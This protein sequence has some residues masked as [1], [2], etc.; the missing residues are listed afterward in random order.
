MCSRD[1]QFWIPT[2]ERNVLSLRKLLEAAIEVARRHRS[3]FL[4]RRR[5]VYSAQSHRWIIWA[6]RKQSVTFIMP[7]D[8]SIRAHEFLVLAGEADDGQKPSLSGLHHGIRRLTMA[9]S[10]FTHD[11]ASAQLIT[12]ICRIH[13]WRGR[14]KR[15]VNRPQTRFR[16][17][18]PFLLLSRFIALLAPRKQ[19]KCFLVQ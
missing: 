5:M 4:V 16:V 8:Y 19:T 9:R 12:S 17:T 1:G 6:F 14:L 13:L 3:H 11:D 15:E 18:K 10:M 7:K 2:I